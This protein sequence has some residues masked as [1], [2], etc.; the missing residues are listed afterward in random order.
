MVEYAGSKRLKV[1]T[2]D[3]LVENNAMIKLAQKCG[4]V[5]T[6]LSQGVYEAEMLFC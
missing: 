4:K 3:I 1:F 2:A 6:K 5:K